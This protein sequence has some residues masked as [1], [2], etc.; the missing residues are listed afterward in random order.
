MKKL[1][2]MLL[3]LTMVLS[4]A[5]CGASNQSETDDQTETGLKSVTVTVVHKDGTVKEF[6]YKT[7]EEYLGPLLEAEGLI[8][9]EEGPYGLVITQVDGEKAVYETDKAY[10]ALYE[11]DEYALQ[12]IDTTPVVDGGTYRLEYTGA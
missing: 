7:D 8:V 10:W 4:L 11:G 6:E 5:A 1:L 12:G 9:G 3:C 2:A